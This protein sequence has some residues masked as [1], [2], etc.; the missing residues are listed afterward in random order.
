MIFPFWLKLVHLKRAPVTMMLLVICIFLYLVLPMKNGISLPRELSQ[1]MS[2]KNFSSVQAYLYENY[3]KQ[4]RPTEWSFWEK[5]YSDRKNNIRGNEWEDF[6]FQTSFKDGHFLDRILELK[7]HPDSIRY[8]QWKKVFLEFKKYQKRDFSGLFGI[9][10][11][12][13]RWSHYFTYQF[14]HSG[15]L[16]LFSNMM[17]L[18]LFGVM[19]EI[20]AGSWACLLLYLLGGVVGGYFYGQTT[21]SNLAPLIGASG[22]V[23]ALIA[24]YLLSEPR[25]YLRFFFFLFPTEG[26]FGDIYLS[27]WWLFSLL[28]LSDVNAILTNP[29][30]SLSVAHTAHLGAILFGAMAALAAKLFSF[31]FKLGETLSWVSHEEENHTSKEDPHWSLH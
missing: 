15:F 1:K 4:E 18:V 16:H 29:E 13:H 6:W 17:L 25:R 9:S 22:S 7:E 30:W 3:I 11:Q 26:F 31:K 2:Q 28:I 23:S 12:G 19:I 14:I 5:R 20:Q 10:T 8:A 27:K 24:F 21:G